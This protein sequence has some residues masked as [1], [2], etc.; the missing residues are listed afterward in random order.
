MDEI[1]SIQCIQCEKFIT[2]HGIPYGIAWLCFCGHWIAHFFIDGKIFELQTG[3][4]ELAMTC[5]VK[6]VKM[7]E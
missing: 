5:I 3:D 1:S 6:I 7:L 4:E 2:P